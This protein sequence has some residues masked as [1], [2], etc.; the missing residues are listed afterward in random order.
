[1]RSAALIRPQAE[2][3]LGRRAASLR[4][5]GEQRRRVDQERCSANSVG[6]SQPVM[7]GCGFATTRAERPPARSAFDDHEIPSL[8]IAYAG[9]IERGCI[10]RSCS[11]FVR[12]ENTG[13]ARSS[14]R[15]RAAQGQC[16]E[17]SIRRQ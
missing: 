5:R 10:G 15:D 1:M 11:L 9:G 2:R 12:T 7:S 4:P 13:L 16:V 17:N 6:A 8:E 14:T 3:G